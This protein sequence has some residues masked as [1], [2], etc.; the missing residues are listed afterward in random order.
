MCHSLS[1]DASTSMAQPLGGLPRSPGENGLGLLLPAEST[2]APSPVRSPDMGQRRFSTGSVPPACSSPG[3]PPLPGAAPGEPQADQEGLLALLAASSLP[4]PASPVPAERLAPV[5]VSTPNAKPRSLI[6]DGCGENCLN[7]LSFIHCDP[8]L[9]PCGDRCGNRCA[10]IALFAPEC[11]CMPSCGKAPP[12]PPPRTRQVQ[13]MHTE[14]GFWGMHS[15]H[16]R[17]LLI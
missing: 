6:R 3:N 8:R 1:T 5:G 13:M 15:P 7:R 17:A 2:A 10:N 12:P 9:C 14:E 16:I 11:N 4:P